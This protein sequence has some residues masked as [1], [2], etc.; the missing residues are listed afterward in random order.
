MDYKIVDLPIT[1][2]VGRTS[3]GLYHR[4]EHAVRIDGPSAFDVVVR[5]VNVSSPTFLSSTS[6]VVRFSESQYAIPNSRNIRL[7]TAA[8]C[9]DWEES[10]SCGIGDRSVPWATGWTISTG[11]FA[12][13]APG[14][15]LPAAD[16]CHIPVGMPGVRGHRA[17]SAGASPECTS[18]KAS[19]S[20][21]GPATH[22]N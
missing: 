5:R 4:A 9:R 19:P 13:Y 20:P 1:G 16:D 14:E 6:E 22:A 2:E 17:R 10:D 12:V 3:D 7:R 15:Y 18:G 21:A 8:Y 11:T